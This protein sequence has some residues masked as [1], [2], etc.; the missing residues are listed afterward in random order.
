MTT[1]KIDPP[2]RSGTLP[3]PSTRRTTSQ[4]PEHMEPPS[5]L[6]DHLASFAVGPRYGLTTAADGVKKLKEMELKSAVCPQRMIM[7]LLHD[8]ISVEDDKGDVVEQFQMDLVSEP[9]C[10][11]SNDP[12][13]V[14]NNVLLFVVKEDARNSKSGGLPTEMHI[15]QVSRHL[16]ILNIHLKFF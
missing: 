1:T 11:Q 2:H 14:F 7:K 13:E 15:F 4:P 5:C 10:H 8:R 3:A 16:N 12:Q 6:V 9:T